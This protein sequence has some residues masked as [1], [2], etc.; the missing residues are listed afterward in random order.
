MTYSKADISGGGGGGEKIH[1][2]DFKP[3]DLPAKP[4]PIPPLITEMFKK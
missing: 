3:P 4:S 2:Q 1:L